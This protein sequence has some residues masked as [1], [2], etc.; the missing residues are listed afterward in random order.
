MARPVGRGRRVDTS[1]RLLRQSEVVEHAAGVVDLLA[2]VT[3]QKRQ[4][5]DMSTSTAFLA[6]NGKARN[7]ASSALS[8]RPMRA[9]STE[10]R[11]ETA[12]NDPMSMRTAPTEPSMPVCQLTS[13]KRR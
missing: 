7:A 1:L 8:V 11:C 6:M 10:W 5:T 2:S 4:R 12:M 3:S 13:V 9:G